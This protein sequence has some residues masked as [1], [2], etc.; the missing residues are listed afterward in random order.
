MLLR[1][2]GY[3]SG[4]PLT[5]EGAYT[6]NADNEIIND[7]D[8]WAVDTYGINVNGH[9]NVRIRRARIYHKGGVGDY[10]VYGFD[11]NGLEIEDLEY[12]R[13]EAPKGQVP[14]PFSNSGLHIESSSGVVITRYRTKYASIGAYIATCENPQLSFIEG[15]NMKGPFPRG[16]LIQFNQCTGG[17]LIENFSCINDRLLSYPEDNI[18]IFDSDGVTIRLGLL[19]G[20]N[21]PTGVGIMFENCDGGLVEDVD[22]VRMGNGSF[23]AYPSNNIVFRRC[24]ARDMIITAQG[25][26]DH[27][28]ETDEKVP[29][30]IPDLPLSGGLCFAGEPSGIDNIIDDCRV[31]NLGGAANMW[32]PDAF[33]TV[34]ITAEDFTPRSPIKL[35][36]PWE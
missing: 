26:D 4:S 3:F 9:E 30:G 36:M 23:A 31:F 8:L 24:R 13:M 6:V 20:N 1:S 12:V 33:L 15:Y 22:A 28:N 19:D 18:N 17:G 2:K 27:N 21:A 5:A 35:V 32:S 14:N 29:D 7:I 16:Q 10:G 25:R 34:D 11:T